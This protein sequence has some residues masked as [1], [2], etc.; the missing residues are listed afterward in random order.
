MED[1][2]L[3][4]LLNDLESDRVERKTSLLLSA[5]LDDLD[6]ELFRRTYL[7]ASLASEIIAENQRSIAEQLTSVR[8]ATIEPQLKPTNLGLLVVGQDPRQFI[9]SAYI[10]FL[11]LDGTELTDPIKAQKEIGGPL[12][13]LLRML[14]ETF[15]AHISVALDIT[16]R[17][18]EIKQ[19]DYPIVALQQLARN[20]V[21]H[22]NKVYRDFQDLAKA[23][24]QQTHVNVP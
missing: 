3:K 7:P 14:D 18:V 2:E 13:D 4:N 17:P 24:A 12:P 19:P 11:R 22:R 15:Q 6:L 16:A 23:I 21:L 5:T 8:F 20:A 1:E 10:Q 9:S